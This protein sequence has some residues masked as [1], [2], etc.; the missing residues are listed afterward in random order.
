MALITQLVSPAL[1]SIGTEIFD[2]L[3]LG[4][5]A[6]PSFRQCIQCSDQEWL[7]IGVWRCLAEQVSGRA[8][9]QSNALSFPNLPD[10]VCKHTRLSLRQNWQQARPLRWARELL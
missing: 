2:P 3:L 4:V 5:E 9:L 6:L 8:F 7:K 1:T 10:Q